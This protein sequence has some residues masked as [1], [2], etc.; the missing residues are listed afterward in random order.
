[1]KLLLVIVNEEYLKQVSKLFADNNISATIIA[2]TGDFLQYGDTIFL[3]GIEEE[4]ANEVIQY[5]KIEMGEDEVVIKHQAS[6]QKEPN[7]R[8][9]IFSLSISQYIKSRGGFIHND[10]GKT[11][12]AQFSPKESR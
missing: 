8:V 12:G 10:R 9:S 5:L 2:S 3:L 7:A 11:E 6:E 4:S 1:M